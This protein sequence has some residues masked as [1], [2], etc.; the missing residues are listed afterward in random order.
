MCC[1]FFCLFVYKT[2][3]KRKWKVGANNGQ[4]MKGA[5]KGSD[6]NGVDGTCKIV[7]FR[8]H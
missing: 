5:L 7:L 2:M 6:S 3:R 8:F 1:V 4:R